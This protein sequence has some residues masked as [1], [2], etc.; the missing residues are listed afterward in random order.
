MTKAKKAN[1]VVDEIDG[2]AISNKA[3]E[4][5][6]VETDDKANT[7]NDIVVYDNVEV[8]PEEA[9][10]LSLPPNHAFYENINVKDVQNEIEKSLVKCTWEEQKNDFVNVTLADDDENL[11]FAHKTSSSWKENKRINIPEPKNTVLEVERKYLKE[12]LTKVV[13]KYK[14]EHCT[15]RGKTKNSNLNDNDEKVLKSLKHKVKEQKLAIYETDKTGKLCIDTLSNVEQKMSAHFVRDDLISEK[16]FKSIQNNINRHTENWISILNIASENGHLRRTK[17]NLINKDNPVPILRGTSKDHKD[18]SDPKIGP[19]MRPIMGANVGPNTGLSQIACEILR[20]IKEN[21]ENFYE[22]R[23]TE[24][25]LR[26]FKDFNQSV[27]PEG[28]SNRVIASMDIDQFYPSINPERAANVARMI[29]EKSSFK[30]EN[31][32]YDKL[33]EYLGKSLKKRSYTV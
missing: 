21:A 28:R 14:D 20:K 1:E 6:D 17:S 9:K 16:Q 7:A 29:G 3:L 12:E 31:V 18:C 27:S 19:K 33:A 15:K 24:E 13:V 32:D 22:I 10:I 30:I 2:I 26:K 4:E 11:N 8:N 25:L 23:N 5:I